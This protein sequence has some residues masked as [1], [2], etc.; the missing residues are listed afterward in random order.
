[1]GVPKRKRSSS[2][3]S[4]DSDARRV[5]ENSRRLRRE[6][7][8][9]R[10]EER[11]KQRAADKEKLLMAAKTPAEILAEQRAREQMDLEE[12]ANQRKL[13]V[14]KIQ[15]VRAK[16]KAAEENE[17]EQRRLQWEMEN[18][19]WHESD[20]D[21]EEDEQPITDTHTSNS[22]AEDHV[23]PFSAFLADNNSKCDSLPSIIGVN[24][25][26]K[27]TVALDEIR[28]LNWRERRKTKDATDE[29]A[30]QESDNN[31]LD[32]LKNIKPVTIDEAELEVKRKEEKE[33]A[34]QAK[35]EKLQQQS[36]KEKQEMQLDFDDADF[37]ERSYKLTNT[38]GKVKDLNPINHDTRDYI[39]FRKDFYVEA[40]AVKTLTPEQ[41]KERRR[42]LDK[43]KVRGECIPAPIEKWEQCGLTES[44]LSDLKSHNYEVPF[45]IQAQAIPL[46][47]SGRDMIGCARTG[48]GKTLAYVLPMIRHILDQPPLGDFDGPIG[49]VLI[50]TRELATQIQKEFVKFGKKVG[51]K[52]LA[53][54]GGVGI[55]EQIAECRR[56]VHVIVGTPGRLIDLMVA[57][58][59]K[60]V[61]TSRASFC[62]LDEAD[63][64]FDLGFGPQ[65]AKIVQNIQPDRQMVMF[66]ATFPKQIE[67][68]A[69]R[70]L[71]NPAEVVIGGRC[72]PSTNVTQFVE[73]FED[74]NHKFL[75]LLQ[76]V[77]EWY[78]KG[79]ILVF[80]K[81]Q[82]EVDILWKSMYDA[83]YSNQCIM[84]HGGMDQIDRDLALHDFD[85]SGKR[86][87]IA[88]SVA[89]RGIDVPDLEL[90]INYTIPSHFE[91]YIHR[92]GRTGRAGKRGTAFSFYTIGEDEQH[93]T[94]LVRALE[95]SNNDIP[96]ELQ[97]IA[98]DFW[99]KKKNG[100]VP[101][102]RPN[103]GFGGRGY[104]FD[105]EES[106]RKKEDIKAQM[107]ARGLVDDNDSE[108]N[109]NPS[110]D[111]HVEV[112]IDKERPTSYT[113]AGGTVAIHSMAK[114]NK[115][116]EYAKT[117]SL[118]LAKA[119]EM[120]E[121]NKFTSEIE[122][123]DYPVQARWKVTNRE[124]CQTILEEQGIEAT[125]MAK[126]IYC[127]KGKAPPGER[128]LYLQIDGQTHADVQSAKKLLLNT[129]D[130]ETQRLLAAGSAIGVGRITGK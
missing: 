99:T 22:M 87:L 65:V 113:K 97:H 103:G 121:Q 34:D 29:P 123:N 52:S 88:T 129:L 69:K 94:W 89:S 11:R 86:V 39:P 55:S 45:P 23:D 32:A 26:A 35:L 105:K 84:L 92:I 61:N 120:A 96:E 63:R 17:Y 36:E 72:N 9:K 128:K 37:K 57:N 20:H 83:G 19:G 100:L 85:M 42:A 90:V 101:Y 59:G 112:N 13:K 109:D 95:S 115:A 46:I 104:K 12:E 54:Y 71:V 28:T 40:K 1:M 125:V 66:S 18:R 14:E 124:Q 102:F 75:R 73:C 15:K 27:T 77:G 130:S 58:K 117:L 80:T 114:V 122:I 51:V 110:D 91:D 60:V 31:F 81:S 53:A 82:E 62:V 107:R 48:S 67:A 119:Q 127:K 33:R 56:G 25:K 30:N 5:N 47:M 21:E 2:S 76:I 79:L 10:K 106:R 43:I 16:V 44:V 111:E 68:A 70:F 98:N 116:Q 3:S 126:G 41:V 78:D 50:P 64:M 118:Q 93:A 7:H 74:A 38:E 49:F 108:E 8:E 6:A 24:D 4:E